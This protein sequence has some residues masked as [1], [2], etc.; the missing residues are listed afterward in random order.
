MTQETAHVSWV[1]FRLSGKS[2]W[3][4]DESGDVKAQLNR[5]AQW[6]NEGGTEEDRT[7][8]LVYAYRTEAQRQLTT[9]L[10]NLLAPGFTKM[11]SDVLAANEKSPEEA[12]LVIKKWDKVREAM[13]STVGNF[14]PKLANLGLVASIE[15]SHRPIMV[16]QPKNSPETAAFD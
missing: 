9:Q 12:K 8:A 11:C 10:P 6:L 3:D 16:I 14:N 13:E 7:I 1:G 4:R 5:A 2:F 15:G